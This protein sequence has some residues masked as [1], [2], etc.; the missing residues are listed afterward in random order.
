[1]RRGAWVETA[2]PYSTPA[3]RPSIGATTVA[4]MS[5]GI[6]TVRSSATASSS[7]CRRRRR[8]PSSCAWERAARPATADAL[9]RAPRP[10]AQRGAAHEQ[11]AGDEQGQH[12]HVHSDVTDDRVQHRPQALTHRAAVRRHPGVAEEPL[13]ALAAEEAERVRSGRQHECEH[14]QHDAG[15]QR[16]SR[17]TVLRGGEHVGRVGERQ[18]REESGEAHEPAEGVAE[19]AAQ[20]AAVPAEVEH[21]GEKDGEGAAADRRQLVAVAVRRRIGSGSDGAAH[22]AAGRLRRPARALGAARSSA[23]SGHTARVRRRGV[24]P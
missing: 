17:T 14:Q 6:R 13:R 23:R 22:H 4:A 12:E 20:A 9:A 24:L 15:G 18:R 10:E 3:P 5:G 8:S 2:G 11:Q 16:A 7:S 1:M 21:E 19:P